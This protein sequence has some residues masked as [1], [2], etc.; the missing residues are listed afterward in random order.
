[1]QILDFLKK[2]MLLSKPTLFLIITLSGIANALLLVVINTAAEQIVGHVDL[3]QSFLLYILLLL[4]FLYTQYY[5]L[6]QAAR[7]VELGLQ[8]MKR[9][10]VNKIQSANL[11]F[12]ENNLSLNY[13]TTLTQDT[14]TIAQASL[15]IISAL[16]SLLVVLF[17]SIYLFFISPLS[18]LLL[19]LF[20]GSLIPIFT[21][22]SHTAKIKL[23][24]SHQVQRVITDKLTDLLSG[25]KE[26]H[27][28]AAASN[29]FFSGLRG[30]VED[31]ARLKIAANQRVNY[32]I[33][34]STLGR[35]LLLL[36]VVFLVPLVTVASTASA[37]H[38]IS[39]ILFI[40]VPITL[41]TNALP[42]LMRTE[43][44][45]ANLY[46]LETVLDQAE[47]DSVTKQQTV[48]STFKQIVLQDVQFDYHPTEISST[49]FGPYNMRLQAGE[50]VFLTG[51]NGS[52][53]STLL[54]L[55]STLYRPTQ[56]VILWDDVPV[57]QERIAD[58]RALFAGVF[59][60]VFLFNQLYGLC[61]NDTAAFAQ[62][63]AGWLASMQL[64]D[65]TSYRPM[66]HALRNTS[67]SIGQQKR[68]A[69]IVSV[70]KKRPILLLDEFTA[71]QAPD[72]R[73]YFYRKV[74]P[75][76]HAAGYTVMLVTH[77]AAYF[78][79]ADRVILIQDRQIVAQ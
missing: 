23:Q 44:S 31:S 54:K 69:F 32:D 51:G 79:L 50:I 66:Q 28:D 55:L 47:Q 2:E 33:V 5:I 64:T 58:F 11:L 17:V 27:T 15:R 9:R 68:L 46:E 29:A 13:F 40:I 57:D 22:N 30:L 7:A 42:T 60:D 45:I 14:A 73:D 63:L 76:L 18:F 67:L 3:E 6:T 1:M 20:L 43:S 59:A 26:L 8:A 10:I 52:G 16:Q 41:L 77:D 70:L 53:K 75:K 74:L 48:P 12:I 61:H 39:T 21:F 37:H 25:F 72:F 19:A 56:G 71:D 38:I 62:V 24:D 35:Y 4:L 34:F 36:L 49:S 65:K 78:E